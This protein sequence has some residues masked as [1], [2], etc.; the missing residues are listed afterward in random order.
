M[1]ISNKNKKMIMEKLT[2]ARSRFWNYLSGRD[3]AQISHRYS[4]CMDCVPNSF[5]LDSVCF[6]WS[7]QQIVPRSFLNFLL[8]FPRMF[9]P[10]FQVFCL[11]LF[12]KSSSINLYT[13]MIFSNK[14]MENY[15]QQVR[16][17]CLFIFVWTRF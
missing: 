12:W 15:H 11:D 5:L 16:K 2:W 10:S 4:S 6:Q 1:C 9:L 17:V 14:R 13:L 8:L 7:F 3:T